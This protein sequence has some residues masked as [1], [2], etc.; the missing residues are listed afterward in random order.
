MVVKMV[1]KKGPLD[2]HEW[3]RCTA[4]VLVAERDYLP[5]GRVGMLEC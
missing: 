5:E 4:L 1:V 3:S 2:Q